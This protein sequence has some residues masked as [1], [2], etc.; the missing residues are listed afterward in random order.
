MRERQKILLDVDCWRM[1]YRMKGVR[2]PNFPTIHF[3]KKEHLLSSTCREEAGPV[4][5]SAGCSLTE[6]V[7]CF[8]AAAPKLKTSLCKKKAALP[9]LVFCGEP[10]FMAASH[11]FKSILWWTFFFFFARSTLIKGHHQKLAEDDIANIQII[12]FHVLQNIVQKG[13]TW[14][15]SI[16]SKLNI[17]FWVKTWAHFCE[18]GKKA[19]SI[20]DGKVTCTENQQ[21]S[22]QFVKQ[23]VATKRLSRDGNVLIVTASAK[24]QQ[25]N[26]LSITLTR[27]LTNTWMARERGMYNWSA[28]IQIL[29]KSCHIK[30]LC[31]ASFP[32]MSWTVSMT[33]IWWNAILKKADF[34][35]L[36]GD[37]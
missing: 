4:Q 23:L 2:P 36:S 21:I 33:I 25:K 28:Q 10:L 17:H 7:S 11:T 14:C 20:S 9:G 19:K 12:C 35:S 37:R 22:S 15:T 30:K 18:I 1:H 13:Q 3:V 27:L 32:K 16:Q 34:Q 5:G 26:T 8:R 31:M 6:E 29:W 24:A